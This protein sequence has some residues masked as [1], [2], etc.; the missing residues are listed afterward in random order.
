MF[1]NTGGLRMSVEVL[2]TLL[3]DHFT[4]RVDV[5]VRKAQN[6]PNRERDII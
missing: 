6:V 1:F 3:S 5:Q 2:G 4:L